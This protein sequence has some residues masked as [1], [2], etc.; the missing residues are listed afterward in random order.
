MQLVKLE[1][2][3]VILFLE[4]IGYKVVLPSLHEFPSVSE[5]AL[6][7]IGADLFKSTDGGHLHCWAIGDHVHQVD[8]GG[9]ISW[10][11]VAGSC[12][13]SKSVG[14][15]SIA[16]THLHGS[17]FVAVSTVVDRATVDRLQQ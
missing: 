4:E 1:I 6:L 7:E 2:L 9:H 5:A 8:C 16:A 11:G 10:C 14:A 12:I 3:H 17:H 15:L 13:L